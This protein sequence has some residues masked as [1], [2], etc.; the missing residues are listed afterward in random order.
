MT[1]AN[2]DNIWINPLGGLGDA[3][4]LSG[5]LQ[6]CLKH[7]PQ[8]RYNL[9]RRTKYHSILDGHP[10]IAHVGFPPK[11]AR[12]IGTDYW[13]RPEYG[14]E[15]AFQSLAAIF[16]LP[17][18]VEERLFMPGIPSDIP[19]FEDIPFG[20][21]N[22]I[23]A[24]ASDSPR[25]ELAGG[26]WEELT[27]RLVADGFFVMQVGKLKNRHVRHSWSLLGLTTPRQL[28]ALVQ[29]A[30]LVITPDNF[31]MHLAHLQNVPAVVLWGPTTAAIYGY[32]G[33]RHL[34][35]EPECPQRTTCIGPANA[36]NYG[37]LCQ[38]GPTAHCMNRI[39]VE[40][41]HKAALETLE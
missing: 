28:A 11:G 22:I 20:T 19:L 36:A 17:L 29:R 27:Q 9:I 15:R 23:I 18:P 8:L 30:D 3:L 34:R 37:A 41:I 21:K 35:A 12:I 14:K 38:L 26:Y 13:S 5:V 7:A 24:P 16:G 32:P 39:G 31:I 4:M 40:V 6:L 2:G 1:E 10:A 25:K 33:H